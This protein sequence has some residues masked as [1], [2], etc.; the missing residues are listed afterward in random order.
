[1]F[2]G[3]YRDETEEKRPRRALSFAAFQIP[4]ARVAL[5]KKNVVH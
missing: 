3:K 5:G 1:M 4:A 2:G